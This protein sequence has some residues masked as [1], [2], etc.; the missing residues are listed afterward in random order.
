MSSLPDIHAP[1]APTQKP[2]A[3][4]PEL[5]KEISRLRQDLNVQGGN[6]LKPALVVP[7]YPLQPSTATP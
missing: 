2:G 5:V 3:P 7:D 6:P 4:D 1:P